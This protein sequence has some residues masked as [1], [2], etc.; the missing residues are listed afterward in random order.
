[1]GARRGNERPGLSQRQR[2]TERLL[3][4]ESQRHRQKPELEVTLQLCRAP[5]DTGLQGRC[6][7]KHSSVLAFGGQ[8]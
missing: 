7:G 8:E 5:P 3:A 2:D 4:G 1:M 6:R